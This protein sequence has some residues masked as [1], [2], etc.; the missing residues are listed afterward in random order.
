M[1]SIIAAVS[2]NRVIGSNGKIPWDI[3]EDK[4]YFSRLT[5]GNVI[6]MG[7]RTYEEIGFALPNRYNIVVSRTLQVDGD[8]ICTA[9]SLEEAITAA[10]EYAKQKNSETEIFLCGGEKIYEQGLEFAQ[11]IYLTELDDDYEGDAFFPEFDRNKFKP[12]Q[13][14][15]SKN[16][17]LSYCV[18]ERS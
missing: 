16:E 12:I 3:P 15:R 5:S 9:E 14:R 8:N 7:R 1:I 11:R 17:K 13:S 2:P 18:Y 10:K 4:S 6:I